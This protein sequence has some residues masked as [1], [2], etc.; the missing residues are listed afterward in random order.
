MLTQEEKVRR[1]VY[2]ALFFLPWASLYLG[3]L[4]EGTTHFDAN[5]LLLDNFL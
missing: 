1:N 5:F 3:N 4:L 2:T